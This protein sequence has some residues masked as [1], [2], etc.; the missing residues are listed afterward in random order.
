MASHGH[1]VLQENRLVALAARDINAQLLL[2]RK[3]A[4]Q[5]EGCAQRLTRRCG[6]LNAKEELETAT[7]REAAPDEM[8]GPAVQV[9]GPRQW[10]T[11]GS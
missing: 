11:A 9:D 4:L 7:R 5:K 2:S 3:W 1:H 10:S 6:W 8:D